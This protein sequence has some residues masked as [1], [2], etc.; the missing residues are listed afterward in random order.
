M[1]DAM[2]SPAEAARADPATLAP[3]R[4][5]RR[6]LIPSRSSGKRV[7]LHCGGG[8]WRANGDPC[9]PS[10]APATGISAWDRYRTSSTSFAGSNAN[11]PPSNTVVPPIVTTHATEAAATSSGVALPVRVRSFKC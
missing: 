3:T 7:H 5:N 8:V 2:R 4:S 6:R 9:C 11:S 10:P 1:E